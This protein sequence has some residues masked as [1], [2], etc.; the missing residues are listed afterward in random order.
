MR[1]RVKRTL[2]AVESLV[3][4]LKMVVAYDTAADWQEP[5][6]MES[7]FN[8]LSWE[9]TH[10]EYDRIP[11]V[12]VVLRMWCTFFSYESHASRIRSMRVVEPVMTAL[13][14]EFLLSCM[15]AYI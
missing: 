3:S 10:L 13:C 2:K 8:A 7:A 1:R 5:K 11:L 4:D 6:A 14:Y 9:D 12:A 15:V